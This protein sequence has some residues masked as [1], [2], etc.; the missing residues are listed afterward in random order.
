ML[1]FGGRRRRALPVNSEI[2]ITNLVD[3]AFV[4]LIIFMITAPILQGGIELQLP[5]GS[6][7]PIKSSDAVVVSVAKDGAIFIEKVKVAS[8][9]EFETVFKTYAGGGTERKVVQLK[10]DTNA[11]FGRVIEVLGVMKDLDVADV[12]F[13]IEPRK[14][15]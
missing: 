11:S 15:R 12:D 2:N 9:E 10:G 13:V 4:L 3:V 8:L 7:S 1:R 5:E 6:A 14:R